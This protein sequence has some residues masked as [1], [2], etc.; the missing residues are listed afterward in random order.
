[1]RPI[2]KWG[3]IYNQMIVDKEE[4]KGANIDYQAKMFSESSIN[5]SHD[6]DPKEENSDTKEQEIS[7]VSI[8][9]NKE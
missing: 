3:E 2:Q 4:P 6:S 9:T 8:I 1:M 7:V 5:E